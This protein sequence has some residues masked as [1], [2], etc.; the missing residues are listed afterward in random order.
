M[1]ELQ[2][3]AKLGLVNIKLTN[4]DEDKKVIEHIRTHKTKDIYAFSR[5]DISDATGI[6]INT[7]PYTTIIKIPNSC[8]CMVSFGF[9]SHS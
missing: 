8:Y 1:K 6:H 4:K 2:Q 7:L 5:K 3:E 9:N